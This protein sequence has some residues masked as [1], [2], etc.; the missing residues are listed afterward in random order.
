MSVFEQVGV[1]GSQG[2]DCQLYEA[3][4]LCWG[5]FDSLSSIDRVRLAKKALFLSLNH[6]DAY[7]IL[8]QECDGGLEEQSKLWE[9]GVE[10]GLRALEE[11]RGYF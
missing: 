8:A 3:E 2:L 10:A 1:F 7:L 11:D 5:A 6:A 4:R 9:Q